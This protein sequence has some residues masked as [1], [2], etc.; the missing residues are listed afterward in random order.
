MVRMPE[1]DL[2]LVY[3]M[4]VGSQIL[5]LQRRLRLDLKY[6][7]QLRPFEVF[8]EVCREFTGNTQLNLYT[9]V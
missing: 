1:L 6:E 7:L 9:G 4:R 2:A 3:P 8:T 5:P